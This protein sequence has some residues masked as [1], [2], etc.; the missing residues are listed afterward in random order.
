MLAEMN[1]LLEFKRHEGNNSIASLSDFSF[2]KINGKPLSVELQ[3]AVT[4][5]I[6]AFN[7][8]P[9]FIINSSGELIDII[10]L[11]ESIDGAGG[12]INSLR[13][14]AGTKSEIDTKKIFASQRARE[15]LVN[16]LSEY[17]MCWVGAWV[18]FPCETGRTKE[19]EFSR[20]IAGGETPIR[21]KRIYTNFGPVT[22]MPGFVHL[23]IESVI[24][25]PALAKEMQKMFGEFDK[26]QGKDVS[27]EKIPTFKVTSYMET[28]IDLKSM[29]PIWAKRSKIIEG[30]E[31]GNG[32]KPFKSVESH[33]YRFNWH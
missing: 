21:G 28:K 16:A 25:D 12:A 5:A 8:F 18:E 33:E 10:G 11:E 20:P 7:S 14:K 2:E 30:S 17:W 9:D 6:Q 15:M 27:K 32:M 3:E 31:T 29:R 24:E 1:Y 4:P 26:E 22:G 23:K 13:E 19:A